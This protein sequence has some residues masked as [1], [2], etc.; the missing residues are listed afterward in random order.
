MIVALEP[1]RVFAIQMNDG[2]LAPQLDDYKPDC[3]SQPC[4]AG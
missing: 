3:L 1:D 2:T 4:G